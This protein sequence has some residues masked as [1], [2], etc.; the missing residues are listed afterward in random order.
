ME[1]LLKEAREISSSESGPHSHQH[2]VA[3]KDSV[4][5]FDR[6]TLRKSKHSK[7]NQPP[8]SNK[9]LTKEGRRK[10]LF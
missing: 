8:E 10:G 2:E 4:S 9:K 3:I 5:V 6:D 1:E 7:S